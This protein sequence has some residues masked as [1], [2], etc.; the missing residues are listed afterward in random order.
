MACLSVFLEN[1]RTQNTEGMHMRTKISI[2]LF[3]DFSC[4]EEINTGWITWQ[5]N[6]GMS[7]I[8]LYAYQVDINDGSQKDNLDLQC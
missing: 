6:R 7:R 3:I 1:I 8:R 4:A 5:L 2:C